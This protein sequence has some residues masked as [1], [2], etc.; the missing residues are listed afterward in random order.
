MDFTYQIG[1]THQTIIKLTFKVSTGALIS[2]ITTS[3]NII[4]QKTLEKNDYCDKAIEGL[5]DFNK[6]DWSH[7]KQLLDF[8]D[9]ILS[10]FDWL[11]I[12]MLEINGG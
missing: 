3:S 6:I 11:F 12:P 8:I 2:V 10:L 7:F 4:F 9:T 5:W 1:T